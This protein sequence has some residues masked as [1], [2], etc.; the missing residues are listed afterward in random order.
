MWNHGLIKRAD[1][2]TMAQVYIA[3]RMREGRDLP[4][5]I[6][7][8]TKF[9]RRAGPEEQTYYRVAVKTARDLLRFRQGTMRPGCKV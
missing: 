6:A 1:D 8:L 3:G 2:L 4:G 5:V 7:D 9:R